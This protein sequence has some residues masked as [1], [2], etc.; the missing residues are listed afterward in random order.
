MT[1]SGWMILLLLLSALLFGAGI[2][3]PKIVSG[4]HETTKPSSSNVYE[5]TRQDGSTKF[6]FERIGT[7]QESYMLFGADS[8]NNN[9]LSDG[10]VAG[11]PLLQARELLRQYPSLGHCGA[12]GSEKARGAIKGIQLSIDSR[13]INSA[14]QKIIGRFNSAMRQSEKRI[15]I[16]VSGPVFKL[17]KIYHRDRQSKMEGEPM[18]LVQPTTLETIPCT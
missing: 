16:K 7:L 6:I 12:P 15:C 8:F 14:L 17:T 18:E 3:L 9:A 5:I 2:Y 11:I 13:S 1:R 10:F 4:Q